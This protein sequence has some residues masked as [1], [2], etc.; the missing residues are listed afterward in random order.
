MK[1][2]KDINLLLVLTFTIDNSKTLSYMEVMRKFSTL[3]RKRYWY[4]YENQ[5]R[6]K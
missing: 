2:I 1:N 6:I 3:V 5:S 4:V